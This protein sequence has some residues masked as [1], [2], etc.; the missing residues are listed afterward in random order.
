MRKASS[1]FPE[2]DR[3]LEIKLKLQNVTKSPYIILSHLLRVRGKRSSCSVRL[4]LKSLSNLT[5]RRRHQISPENLSASSN[6]AGEL[7]GIVESRR[8]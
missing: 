2:T 3:L 5:G 6:L 4:R 8:I 7:V 1:S